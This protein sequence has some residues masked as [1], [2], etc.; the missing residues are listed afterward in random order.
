MSKDSLYK[1]AL[2]LTLAAF[3]ARFLGVV[4]RIPLQQLLGDEGM[5]YYTVAQNVYMMMLTIATAGIPSTLSKMVSER[6]AIGREDEAQ[7]VFRAAIWFS[8]AAGVLVTIGIYASAPFYAELVLVPGSTLSVQAIAPILLLFPMIAMLRGYFQGRRNMTANGISQIVEQIVRV[9]AA[10]GFAYLFV[11]LGYDTAWASAAASFGGVLG[12]AGALAVMGAAWL[13]LRRRDRRGGTGGDPG[14]VSATM[15]GQVSGHVAKLESYRSIYKQILSYGVPIAFISAMVA[16]VSLIDSSMTVPLLEEE[17]GK[18]RATEVLGILGG[19]AMSLAGLPAILAIAIAQ[20]IVPIVSEAHARGDRAEVERQGASAMRLGVLSGLPVVLYIMVAAVPIN[21][22]LFT[23]TQGSAIIAGLTLS[24]I[25]QI[26]M[27]TSYA[28]LLGLG[29]INVQVWY[30]V[31]GIVVKVAGNYALA[32]LFG[33]H[34]I[35][36]ATSLAFIVTMWLNIRAMR[37]AAD[38]RMFGRSWLGLGALTTIVFAVGF[39][40]EW[41]LLTYGMLGDTVAAMKTSYF[42]HAA[43]IGLVTMPLYGA[44]LVVFRV[45]TDNDISRLP[46]P[47]RR[48]VA[49]LSRLRVAARQ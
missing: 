6:Y 12:A 9:A 41:L 45:M 20:S 17:L 2:I 26:V 39:A 47:L 32:P 40:L 1:G 30:V 28:I 29:I 24:T 21:G 22:L 36:A 42:V 16:I 11:R 4:Q 18:Q 33:I 34:G 3:V 46:G 8:L 48:I 27:L 19:R 43:V 13:A 31:A 15:S 14:K 7:R 10:V 38:I 5:A 44:L 49:K 35:V 23:D 37:K 25:F